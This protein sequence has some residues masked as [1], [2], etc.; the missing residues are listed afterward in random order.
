L[1]TRVVGIVLS[2]PGDW[3]GLQPA[4]QVA[5]GAAAAAAAAAGRAWQK[6]LKMSFNA[7]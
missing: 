7:F 4:A 5:A 6:M 1:M 3:Q 2:G